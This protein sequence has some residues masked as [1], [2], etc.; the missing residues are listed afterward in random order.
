MLKILPVS[1]FW[2]H[3]VSFLEISI[4][5][6]ELYVGWIDDVFRAFLLQIWRVYAE[7]LLDVTTNFW[8]EGGVLQKLKNL[9]TAVCIIQVLYDSKWAVWVK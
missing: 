4:D 2:F 8:G 6:R 5:E 3:V 1:Y 7:I 9:F